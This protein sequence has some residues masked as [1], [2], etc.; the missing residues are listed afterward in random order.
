MTVAAGYIEDKIAETSRR[1]CLAARAKKA[2]P[3]ISS[4]PAKAIPGSWG[5]GGGVICRRPKRRKPISAIDAR[6]AAIS[7][8]MIASVLTL[9]IQMK[10]KPNPVPAKTADTMSSLTS[11]FKPP[12]AEKNQTARQ[13]QGKPEHLGLLGPPFRK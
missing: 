2:L 4:R 13:G 12:D 3:V 7:G 5:H 1:P 11:A 6:R 8:H 10:N 9:S